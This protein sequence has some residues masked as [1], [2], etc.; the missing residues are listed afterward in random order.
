V[1]RVLIYLVTAA[2]AF[3]LSIG[4]GYGSPVPNREF[5]VFDGL[6][7]QQK[8]DLTALGMHPIIQINP[9]QG[10]YDNVYDAQTRDTM[11]SLSDFNGVVYLDYES[12][13]L[14]GEKPEVIAGN[15][16]KFTHVAD[17]AH[18]AAPHAVF[19]FYG[20]MPCREYW[21]LVNDDR[22]K[23]DEWKECNRQ[24]EAIANHVEWR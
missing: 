3:P 11:K 24:G 2:I 1:L 15:V 19:G 20:L 8:P 5:L 16:E 6:L 4:V 13:P 9:P 10:L 22:K 17:I 18:Q 14:S 7:Y 23:I 12:W 21:G